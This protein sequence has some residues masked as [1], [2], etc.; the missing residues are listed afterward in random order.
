MR[1]CEVSGCESKYLARGMCSKHYQ[2]AWRAARP[3]KF[4]TWTPD[5]DSQ[6]LAAGLAP[7]TERYQPGGKLAEVAEAL[8]VT[9]PAARDRLARLKR[10]AGHTGGQWTT[11]GLWTEEE[12][13]VIREAMELDKPGWAFVAADL[14]RT[15]GVCTTRAYNL[16][17]GLR[18]QPE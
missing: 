11:E 5:M 4:R 9:V 17:H 14:G 3:P 10:K 15:K 1:V 18:G 13:A 8:G 6:L 2:R 12:D 16:R 7:W